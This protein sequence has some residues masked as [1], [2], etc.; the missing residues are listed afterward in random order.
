MP[1]IKVWRE[2]SC[3]M[4]FTDSQGSLTEC[5]SPEVRFTALIQK[6]IQTN[7]VPDLTCENKGK[8]FPKRTTLLAIGN[9]IGC[10]NSHPP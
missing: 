6:L 9:Q 10:P 5:A 2:K 4:H 8:P 7:R 3:P 1:G